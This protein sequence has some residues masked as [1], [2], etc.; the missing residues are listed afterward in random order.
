MIRNDFLTFRGNAMDLSRQR[1]S[2]IGFRGEMLSSPSSVMLQERLHAE[3]S[4]ERL[5]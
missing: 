5:Q 3:Y 2:L 4:L 1:L